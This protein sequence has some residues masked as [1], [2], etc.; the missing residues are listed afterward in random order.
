MRVESHGMSGAK[1]F[2]IGGH[3]I[4]ADLK[5]GRALVGSS[6]K[7]INGFLKAHRMNLSQCYRSTVFKEKLS[8]AGHEKRKL[9]KAVTEAADA[10]GAGIA[11]VV[12]E[13]KDVSPNVVVPLDD[14]ALSA[15]MP[16]LDTW[17]APARKKSWVACYRGS[18]LNYHADSNIKVIPTLGPQILY[19][20][21]NAAAYV[22]IDYERIAKYSRERLA[23]PERG[24]IWVARTASELQKFWFRGMDKKPDFLTFDIETYGGLITCISFCLDGNEAVSIPLFDSSIPNGEMAL[25]WR[26]VAK[27]LAHPIPKC[28]QNIK[29]DITILERHG[30]I[31]KNVIHDTMLKTGMIY[32]EFPKGLDFLTSIYTEIP[33]YK[34]E[35]KTYSPKL[36]TKDRLYL[37]NAKDSLSASIINTAQDAELEEF[38]MKELY[39]EEVAPLII[40]YKEMDE[41]RLLIDNAAKSELS[42]KYESKY[43]ANLH[44][45]RGLVGDNNFNPN[46]SRQVGKLLYQDLKFP[47]RQKVNVDTGDY[48]YKTDKDTLDDLS[49]HWADSNSLGKL[50]AEIIKRIIFCRKLSRVRQYID[51]PLFPDGTFGAVSNLA[52]TASGRSSSSKSLDEIFDADGEL[53]RVGRSLQTIGKH[54]FTVDEEIF[55][56]PGDDQIASD[57]RKMFVP[58]RGFTFVEGDGSQAEARVVAVL[59]EDYEMLAMFDQKPN[60]HVK[61]AA[62]IFNVDTS[63]IGKDSPC[64]PLLGTPYYLIGKKIRHAGNY[65]MGEFRLAQMTHMSLKECRGHLNTFHEKTPKLREVFHK[66]VKSFVTQHRFLISPHKRRRAFFKEFTPNVFKEAFSYIPQATVSDHTKFS[67]RRIKDELP[68]VRFLTEQ[69]DGILAEIPNDGVNQY[70]ET[71]KR[72]YERS[73]DFRNCSLYR[74]MDLVIPCELSTSTTNWMELKEVKL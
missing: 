25:I 47:K 11:E 28:N 35:G 32:A 61:T 14:L 60:I 46:S 44:T 7:I 71:F 13:I 38:G 2:F 34:D 15:V 48:S 64:I 26:T 12:Q 45:L 3:P 31:V 63:I 24:V 59:A 23:T 68:G 5:E 9:K 33:Y 66:Q 73:I 53:I 27:I 72:I 70:L 40:I 10:F 18:V 19:V 69:H 29:Y 50:G 4:G 1:I 41:T 55:D 16:T 17:K 6:E 51:T 56:A 36:H 65:D 20:D 22:A 49:I 67:M 39:Y 54:G 57:L 21:P 74:E 43:D 62:F 30:F 52:G 37:Y 8:Y 42:L 58:R